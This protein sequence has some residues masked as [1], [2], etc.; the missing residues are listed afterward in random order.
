[1]LLKI[2]ELE[3]NPQ[4][5]KS[6]NRSTRKKLFKFKNAYM[7][8]AVDMTFAACSSSSSLED[9]PQRVAD[10]LLTTYQFTVY[11]YRLIVRVI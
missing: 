4:K 2:H 9:G 7:K 11:N 1:M 3:K 6:I 10:C 5:K 8:F